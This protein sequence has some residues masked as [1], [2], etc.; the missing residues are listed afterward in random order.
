[1]ETWIE[2][3]DLDGEGFALLVAT[4]P[5]ATARVF[6]QGMTC[7]QLKDN[8]SHLD[9]DYD[10]ESSIYSEG[11]EEEVVPSPQNLSSDEEGDDSVV[12]PGPESSNSI[13]NVNMD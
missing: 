3:R 5:E 11:D 12:M 6:F 13:S 9:D 1:M 10:D 4:L 2:P 8:A 7:A